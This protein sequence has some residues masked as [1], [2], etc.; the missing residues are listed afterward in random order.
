MSFGYLISMDE[1]EWG[2]FNVGIDCDMFGRLG[3][4]F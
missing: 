1:C 4:R 3:W 2:G